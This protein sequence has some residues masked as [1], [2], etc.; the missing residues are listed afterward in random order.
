MLPSGCAT[1]SLHRKN[2]MKLVLHYPTRPYPI[3]QRFGEC[4][5][6]VCQAYHDMGLA[7]HNGIDSGA[8]DGQLVRAAHD[9]EVTFAGE[10]GS[11]GLGVVVRTKQELEYKDAT[12]FYKTIYWHLKTMKIIVVPGQNVRAG[13]V[14]A[15]ADNTGMSTGT[16]LHFG[17]KPVYQGEQAWE[18][19]NHEQQNGYKGA[20][21]PMPFF[22]GKFADEAFRHIF[23]KD[24]DYGMEGE[25][26]LMLQTFLQIK[27]QFPFDI[28]PTGFFGSVT[29]EAVK[30]FQRVNGIISWGTPSTTGYGRVGPKT[31]TKINQML[32]A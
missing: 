25:D 27:G 8:Y 10:D 15:G 26:V 31:R 17:L 23:S 29:R 1:S 13:Q 14:L 32:S 5:A 20:I 12:A 3:G 18:W 19:W 7:G 22:S 28:M 30:T 11:A 2:D 21:D 4:F 6:S 16:H 24:L 9:G